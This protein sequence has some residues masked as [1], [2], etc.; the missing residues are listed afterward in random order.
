MEQ[1]IKKPVM[2]EGGWHDGFTE[3]L[4]PPYLLNYSICRWQAR[5]ISPKKATSKKYSMVLKK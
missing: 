5:E 4:Q 2:P 3:A 1:M